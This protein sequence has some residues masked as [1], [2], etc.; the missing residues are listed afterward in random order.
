[1]TEYSTT[2]DRWASL[3]EAHR[4]ATATAI[5]MGHKYHAAEE[6]WFRFRSTAPKRTITYTV[7]GFTTGYVTL[8]THE[9][10][11]TLTER[12]CDKP[13]PDYRNHPDFIAFCEEVQAWRDEGAGIIAAEAEADQAWSEALT[14]VDN[15][16]KALAQYQVHDFHQ[17]TEKLAICNPE[18]DDTEHRGLLL[19]S[20]EADMRRL[21]GAL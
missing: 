17:I 6:N 16:W 8:A 18:T 3:I 10:T 5:E 4:E 19:D 21:T 15:A 14:A 12:N 13:D 11:A 1:M 2:T 9:R 7:K 20:I